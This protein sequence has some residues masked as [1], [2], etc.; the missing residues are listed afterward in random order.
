MQEPET[1]S[2]K[3][4]S[5]VLCHVTSLATPFGVG[6]LGPSARSFVDFLVSSGQTLWQMLPL[7]PPAH[8]YSPYSCYSAM[9]GNRVMISPE[10]LVADDLATQ[11]MADACI[12]RN[13]DVCFV[14]FQ[15]V[16]T[17]KDVLLRS[18][19]LTYQT[20]LESGGSHEA[21]MAEAFQAFQVAQSHWLEDFARYEALM[22]HFNMLDWT[23]WPDALPRQSAE[24]IR[25]WDDSLSDD[26]EYSKFVQFLFDRQ[27][28]KLK[29]YANERTV[30]LCG[31][32]PIFVAH[33]SSDVWVNQK[34]FHLDEQGK[35]ALVAGVP[36][37]YFSETGQRWG[38]PLYDWDSIESDDYRWWTHR[39]SRA[40]E[41]F[42][43]LRVDHFRG[44]E[45]Y[46]EVAATE[47]TAVNGR[48]VKGPGEKPFRA[49]ESKL[50]SLPL[51]AEDL[52]MI[53]EEVYALRDDLGFPGMRVLQF[54]FDVA[55][56]DFHRP[57][58]YPVSCVAYTGTH[59][60]DTVMG[61]YEKR[62]EEPVFADLIKPYLQSDRDTHLQLIAAVLQSDASLT[63]FPIQDIL[64]RGNEARMNV[65]GKAK[66]NWAWR[67]AP[68]VLTDDVASDLRQL[69]E[70]SNRV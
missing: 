4:S 13:A 16:M 19:F 48:W 69:T 53:T 54:G 66:G 14:D 29:T 5:G 32:M 38:N 1:S 64:G 61:W 60:N 27:W 37:D 20:N 25:K 24:A 65:P 15:Q 10:E 11:A 63:I 43:L 33:E 40:I 50:G 6:D 3:R 22:M 39:F 18:A 21:D 68:N 67:L 26:I 45:A 55:D 9:A 52:G 57:N 17:K 47:E 28:T 30:R 8:N 51:I 46:W 36:P 44:F 42:D 41:Q 2:P 12:I 7:G 62:K 70:E 49:A 58:D 31:D 35:P 23:R 59:D 56:Q 34:L